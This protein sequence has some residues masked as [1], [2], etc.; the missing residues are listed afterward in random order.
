MASNDD[1]AVVDLGN[2]AH[3]GSVIARIDGQ[4]VFVRG[5]VPGEKRVTIAC[6]DAPV[7]ASKKFR[8][9]KVVSVERP[10]RH[11]VPGQCPAAA[12]GA[13]CCDLDF[14]DAEGSLE[15]KKMVVLDQLR[16]IGK[17][18][19]GEDQLEGIR[20]D[21]H[22]HWRTR[23]RLGTEVTETSGANGQDVQDVTVGL[24][25]PKSRELVSVDDAACAQWTEELTDGVRRTL[26]EMIGAAQRSAEASGKTNPEIATETVTEIAV[27]VGDDG[28]CGFEVVET[29]TIRRAKRGRGRGQRNR[30]RRAR[31]ATS[32]TT[33]RS[34]GDLP[35]TVTRTLRLPQQGTALPGASEEQISGTTVTWRLPAH[36]FW[37]GHR[38]A[39]EAYAR[40]VDAVIPPSTSDAA[41]G[42]DLYGGSGVFSAVLAGKVAEVACVDVASA[43]T[44]VGESALREAGIKSVRFVDADVARAL[45]T[46]AEDVAGAPGESGES[47]NAEATEPHGRELHAVVLDPPRTGAGVDV[48]RA[49]AQCSPRHVVHI[50]CDPATAARDLAAWVQQGYRIER[51]A[52]VDA[53]GLTHHVEVLAYLVR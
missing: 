42:W 21:P 40:W 34:L 8:T 25:K 5:G 39:A 10:S 48:V 23:T 24:R 38:A 26:P 12:A 32:T 20:L 45:P 2:P 41:T 37:Q 35:T 19:L 47:A 9:A 16:R 11:R 15:Y 13:G 18:E 22:T 53:F 30:N 27:A 1:T 14:I 46:L 28:E 43:A 3:G 4:V 33:I 49:I 51:I 36:T 44:Q 7:A 50:G 17:L 52:A 6:D 29:S 31:T